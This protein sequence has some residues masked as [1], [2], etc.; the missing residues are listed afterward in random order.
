MSN[1]FEL[2]NPEKNWKIGSL[3]QLNKINI[4]GDFLVKNGALS[5]IILIKPIY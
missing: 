1:I 4:S 3:D 5:Q 2:L